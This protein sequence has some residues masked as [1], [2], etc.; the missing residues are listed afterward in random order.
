M[1]R[2]TVWFVRLQNTWEDLCRPS[3]RMKNG[4][5][6]CACLKM[7]A[8][9]RLTWAD[10]MDC[11]GSVQASGG[12]RLCCLSCS[13][14]QR[15]PLRVSKLFIWAQMASLTAS[16]TCCWMLLHTS[17]AARAFSWNAP[18]LSSQH[19][20]WAW[21]LSSWILR[22]PSVFKLVMGWKRRGMLVK[23]SE[24]VWRSSENKSP[25]LHVSSSRS[26]P[27][28]LTCAACSLSSALVQLLKQLSCCWRSRS[29]RSVSCCRDSSVFI[30]KTV[31]DPCQSGGGTAFT[32][33]H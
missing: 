3:D 6:R 2:S 13:Q 33:L 29:H 16:L 4:C 20:L 11:W 24:F 30:W 25:L 8:L 27:S 9:F 1:C 17:S 5:R 31:E 19:K 26:K 7:F 14:L 15:F 21:L 10:F 28:E 23:T 32:R 22:S 12:S 18:V